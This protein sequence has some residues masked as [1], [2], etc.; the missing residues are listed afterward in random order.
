MGNQPTKPSDEPDNADPNEKKSNPPKSSK[1]TDSTKERKQTKESK[2]TKETK[3]TKEGKES[4]KGRKH[5]KEPKSTKE[6]KS[7]KDAKSTKERKKK[8]AERRKKTNEANSSQ[9]VTKSPRK[10]QSKSPTTPKNKNHPQPQPRKRKTHADD[11]F[12]NKDLELKLVSPSVQA[13]LKPKPNQSSGSNDDS[14]EV[15]QSSREPRESK[16][17]VKQSNREKRQSKEA[18][19][20]PPQ[21][22]LI[23]AS[24]R[25]P[26][27][28]EEKNN[29]KEPIDGE[30]KRKS[31]SAE[32]V[33]RDP[34]L[35]RISEHGDLTIKHRGDGIEPV[36]FSHE[37]LVEMLNKKSKQRYIGPTTAL[38]ILNRK[39]K[40]EHTY[41]L[42]LDSS[43]PRDDGKL[44]LYH[45]CFQ[46]LEMGINTPIVTT[47]NHSRTYF[48]LYPAGT[49]FLDLNMLIDHINND[50]TL[51][52]DANLVRRI[53]AKRYRQEVDYNDKEDK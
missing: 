52:L 31:G 26:K 4:E 14:P 43:K 49:P 34:N 2:H 42:Y 24:T 15:K 6:A 17:E 10:K 8:T 3:Q 20:E 11:V 51:Y 39:Q 32:Q 36:Y 19:E 13:A 30:E 23:S 25:K 29:S 50:K 46:T 38:E 33:D 9:K 35:E 53:N 7:T 47:N 37:E 21:T 28:H 1:K 27:E 22:L 48:R 16:K 44:G 5:T 12:A 40:M 18:A 41:V 45:F